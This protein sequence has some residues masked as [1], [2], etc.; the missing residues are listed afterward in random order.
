MSFFFS[1]NDSKARL[2]GWILLLQVFDITIKDKKNTENIVVNYLSRLTIEL[3]F[4]ITPIN[5][6]FPD[7]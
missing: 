5:S 7:E 6:Y 2:I 3:T 4:D 1:K